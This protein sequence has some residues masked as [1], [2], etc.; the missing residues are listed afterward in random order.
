MK[1][2]QSEVDNNERL[3]Y[4]RKGHYEEGQGL[5]NGFALDSTMCGNIGRFINH[6]FSPNLIAKEVFYDHD[7]K[8]VPHIMFF[9]S[10]NIGHSQELTYDYTRTKND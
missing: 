2:V 3:F 7:D 5:E 10:K 4:I 1:E 9:A 6:N 8:R